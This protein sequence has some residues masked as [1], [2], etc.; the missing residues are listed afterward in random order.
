MVSGAG[1]VHAL[2]PGG[3]V[4]NTVADS[5]PNGVRKRDV[6]DEL[7]QSPL[8]LPALVAAGLEANDRAKYLLTL[9][10][11]SAMTTLTRQMCPLSP[12]ETSD[13]QPGSPTRS[14]IRWWS[15]RAASGDDVYSVPL[16]GPRAC[17]ARGCD[18]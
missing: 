6:L 13:W 5:A 15:A 11:A 17:G 9:L 10:Q 8:L 14:S 4:A 2:D 1:R 16:A 7:G 3:I 12:F 18:R